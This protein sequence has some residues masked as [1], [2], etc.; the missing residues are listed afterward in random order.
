VFIV[1]Y[2]GRVRSAG[3]RTGSCEDTAFFSTLR[4][5]HRCRRLEEPPPQ[6]RRLLNELFAESVGV[7]RSSETFDLI[8]ERPH[9][10]YLRSKASEAKFRGEKVIV[11]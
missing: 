4:F 9:N 10:G 2:G 11:V 3:R 7:A 6:P 1:G 5:C 8:G